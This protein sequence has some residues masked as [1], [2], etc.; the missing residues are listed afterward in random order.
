MAAAAALP[1]DAT[2]RGWWSVVNSG[3][4]RKV[5][6]IARDRWSRPPRRRAYGARKARA[7]NLPVDPNHRG[8]CLCFGFQ[9]YARRGQGRTPNANR[10]THHHVGRPIETAK[11]RLKPAAAELRGSHAQAKAYPRSEAHEGRITTNPVSPAR[12]H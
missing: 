3:G 2:A 11:W 5:H 4:D 8:R 7:R 9:V 1:A 12:P 10:H 6:M